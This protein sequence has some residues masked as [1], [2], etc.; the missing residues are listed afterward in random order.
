MDQLLESLSDIENACWTE[1]ERASAERGH[2]WRTMSLATT[3]GREAHARSVIL[4]EVDREARELLFFT[5]AR[6]SK[7]QQIAQFPRGTLLV[8][9]PQ[10]GWQL[11][12]RVTLEVETA[13]LAVSSRWA[14]LKLTPAAQDY[15]SPLPPGTPLAQTTPERA[16]RGHFALVHAQVRTM[17]WLELLP[18]GQRRACFDRNGYKWV[19]P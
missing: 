10:L 6:S 2:P 3:D 11:R 18:Q 13:G 4:R 16:S 8:W 17:D 14:Q 19:Q 12:L 5:D 1:L 15:L 7:V 9:S